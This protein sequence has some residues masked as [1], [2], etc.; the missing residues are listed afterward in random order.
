MWQSIIYWKKQQ[1]VDMVYF[2][3]RNVKLL[4]EFTKWSKRSELHCKMDYTLGRLCKGCLVKF[5]MMM[6]HL[7]WHPWES[8]GILADALNLFDLDSTVSSHWTSTSW[9]YCTSWFSRISS[10]SSPQKLAYIIHLIEEFPT[11]WDKYFQHL[12][13]WKH[14]RILLYW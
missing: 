14:S 7:K 12:G 10:G 13:L 1:I 5:M 8:M 6:F 2:V 9:R 4:S 3:T 11:C